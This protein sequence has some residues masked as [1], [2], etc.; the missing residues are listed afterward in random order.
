MT[1][2]AAPTRDSTTPGWLNSLMKVLLHTPGLQWV[3]GRSV[4]LITF[5]GRRTGRSYTTPVSYR[6]AGSSVT[7]L[8]RASRVWW[9]NLPDE[10]DVELRMVGRTHTGVARAGIGEESDLGTLIAFLEHRRFD[11]KAYGVTLGPDGRPA[12]A[13][14]RR[15]LPSIV[16]IRV[17]LTDAPRRTDETETAEAAAATADKRPPL[18]LRFLAVAGGAGYSPPCDRRWSPTRRNAPC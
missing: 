15:L 10:P 11:A 7:I 13:D 16:V 9:R 5:Q 12:E 3:F 14:A 17:E 6:R 18:P 4:A 1:Q 8:S 2:A